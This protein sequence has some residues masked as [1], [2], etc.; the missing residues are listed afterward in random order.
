MAMRRLAVLLGLFTVLGTACTSGG[1]GQTSTAGC[2]GKVSGGPVTV[3]LWFHSG[4]GAERDVVASQ[5]SAF[6]ASRSDVKVQLVLLPE[7][8]YNDQVKAAAAGGQLPDILDFD[9]P[10]LYNYAWS[11]NLIPMDSCISSDLKAD[12]LPSIVAQG[13]YAKH[14]YGV[15]SIDSGLG[16]YTRK[17]L[18]TKNGIRIPSGPQDAWSA[19]EFSKI[20]K[21]LQGAGFKKPLDLKLNYG[22]T[23]WYTY[24]FSPI[25]QSAG[26]DLINRS[27]YQSAD[28]VLNSSASVQALTVFQSWFKAGYVDPNDDDAA[29]KTGRSAISWVGHWMFVDYKKVYG[30]DLVILPLPNFGTGS[31]TG[32]GSWQWGITSNAKSVDAAWAFVNYLLQDKQIIQYTNANGAVPA[33]KSAIA[34]SPQFAQG[35]PEYIYVVQ[36]QSI[37]VPR[38]QTPAYPTITQ[39]FTKAIDDIVHGGDVKTALDNAVR[40]IDK[41][42]KSNDGYP[43]KG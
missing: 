8:Q 39:A 14:L 27:N 31:K 10:F 5:V 32:M 13:T 35:S 11:R 19:D 1:G 29:F 18:L 40:T 6:N 24:G 15:G 25:I 43:I 26:G 41:D 4:T 20:L 23:E 7:G 42:I 2:T 22:A 34:Q 12:L 38:P 17:S 30:D 36:L 9:G 21:T 3:K 28:G 33:T 16:L 37:A